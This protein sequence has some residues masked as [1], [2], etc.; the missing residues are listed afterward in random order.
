MERAFT[1]GTVVSGKEGA[2]SD[3]D[4]LIIS[5]V[6]FSE[7]VS[8][9]YPVQERPGRRVKPKIYRREEWRRMMDSKDAFVTEVMAKLRLDVIGG[10]DGSG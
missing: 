10:D 7:V 3:I 6:G 9:L 1:F 4:L 2:A 8:A 5:E